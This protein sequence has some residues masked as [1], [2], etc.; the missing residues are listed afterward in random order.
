VFDQHQKRSL[1]NPQQNAAVAKQLA[2]IL[3]QLSQIE[4]DNLAQ[5]PPNTRKILLNF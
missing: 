1:F 2:S 4:L 3:S 5:F